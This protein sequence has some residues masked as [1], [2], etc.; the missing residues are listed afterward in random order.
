MIRYFLRRVL[1]MI[2]VVFIVTTI[3]FIISRF[4]PGD[5][6]SLWVGGH[7]TKEQLEI[8]REK[9]GFNDPLLVQYYKYIKQVSSFDLGVSLR[10]QQPVYG[11][12]EKRFIATFELV[13]VSFLIAVFIG[14]PVGLIIAI[15]ENKPIDYFFR[16]F[17]YL[18][19]SIPVFWLGMILQLIFFGYLDLFPLQGRF[20]WFSFQGEARGSLL[21]ICLFSGDWRM[22]FDLSRHL[23][24]PATTLALSIV[25]IIIRTARSVTID[26]MQEN[27]FITF[28]SYGFKPVEIISKLGYKNTLI[29][30]STVVG[31]S[32][33]LLLGGTFLLETVFDWPG[34]GQFSTLSILTNDY[35]AIIGVTLLYT[36][37]YVFIN[38]IVDFLYIFLDPRLRR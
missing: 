20:S 7:P 1:L 38:L 31:L 10:T 28:L 32:Y 2:I 3:T 15:K 19:L 18:G 13:T 24:L 11:E 30:F 17:G 8:A 16:G 12:I 23:F 34:L 35:P 5:P 29:P 26:T 9:F 36:L 21:L 27:H 4:L 14:F 37:M 6:A 25:G 22:F 33:G